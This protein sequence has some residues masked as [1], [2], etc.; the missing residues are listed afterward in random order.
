MIVAPLGA[1]VIGLAVFRIVESDVDSLA[2]DLPVPAFRVGLVA[3][4]A[5]WVRFFLALG[6][7]FGAR[8]A[9]I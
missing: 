5:L 7:G 3:P 4:S 9:E 1:V 6:F 8:V 2:L